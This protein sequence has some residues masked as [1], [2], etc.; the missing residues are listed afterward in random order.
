LARMD[1]CSSDEYHEDSLPDLVLSSAYSKDDLLDDDDDM[2]N[3]QLPMPLPAPPDLL[4]PEEQFNIEN[5]Y[6][7]SGDQ[8]TSTYGANGV[9]V[10][11]SDHTKPYIPKISCS[12]AYRSYLNLTMSSDFEESTQILTEQYQSLTLSNRE[13][14]TQEWKDDLSKTELEIENLRKEILK[15]VRHANRLKADLGITAWREFSTDIKEGLQKLQESDFYQK[16][17]GTMSDIGETIDEFKDILKKDFKAAKERAS[18]EVTTAKSKTITELQTVQKKTSQSLSD[19][20]RKA[21]NV[22]R[23]CD[24]REYRDKER[25]DTANLQQ[26]QE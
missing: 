22:L 20:Q 16:C 12:K 13:A 15:K 26:E 4:L 2:I 21:T 8:I 24:D 11:Y 18:Q 6:F 3:Y 5:E 7:T 10:A 19:L 25:I 17:G 1:D 9:R 14:Q 23:N